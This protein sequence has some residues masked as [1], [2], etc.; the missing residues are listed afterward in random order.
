MRGILTVAILVLPMHAYAYEW[1]FSDA[2]AVTKPD[3]T[4][5]FRHMESSGRKNIAASGEVVAVTWEDNRTGSPQT[6][7][8]F[9]GFDS[10][11]FSS[12]IQLSTGKNAYEPSIVSL[13]NGSFLAAWEQDGHVVTR[14]VSQNGVGEMVPL[15]TH[16]SSQVS[17]AVTAK[18]KIYSAWASR[19][20]GISRIV[21]A[22]L[23]LENNHISVAQ[24][25]PVDAKPPV[26]DQLYPSLAAS[27]EG[28]A[29]A[30]E[31]RRHMHTRLYYSYSTDGSKFSA[32]QLLN[33]FI[34][35]ENPQYGSGTGVTRVAL[36]SNFQNLVSATWMDKRFFQGGYDIYASTSEDGGRSFSKNEL[37]QDIG[38]ENIPQWHPAIAVHPTGVVVVAWD[39]NRYDT[40]DIWISWRE[41]G[42]WSDDVSPVQASGAGAQSNPAITI[43]SKGQLHMA[44]VTRM[45]NQDSQVFYLSGK[46]INTN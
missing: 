10:T 46:L 15:D 26:Q 45:D 42:V 18:G 38:G 25:V 28:V 22:V 17:M 9:K 31:D 5:T 6:F 16:D 30:W 36:A 43:D 20:G 29:I 19:D 11:S 2:I 12:A 1:V 24:V 39:D 40:P 33:Q 21:S 32:P 44:W 23:A 4:G 3:K 34:P 37:V 13:H 35:S 7:V 27:G 41:H 8:A 14:L